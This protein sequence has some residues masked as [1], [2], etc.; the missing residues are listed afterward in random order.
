V[1]QQQEQTIELG[2]LSDAKSLTVNLK[3]NS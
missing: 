3:I 1:V 2:D